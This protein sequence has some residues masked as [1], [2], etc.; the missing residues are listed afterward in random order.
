MAKVLTVDDSKVVRTM[1]TKALQPFAC[2][3][4]EAASGQ[5]GVDAAERERPDLILLDVAMPVMD[6]LQA[7]AAIRGNP[8]T[9]STPVIM[10]T[11]ESSKDLGAEIVRL[12]VK[13]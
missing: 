4:V 10:L 11:T 5:E 1:V 8:V 12:G 2:E 6:G 13:G 9:K 3:V 7:L